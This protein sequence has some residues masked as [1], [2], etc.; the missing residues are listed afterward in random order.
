MSRRGFRRLLLLVAGFAVFA[1]VVGSAWMIRSGVREARLAESRE[2]GMRLYERGEHAMALPL[3]GEYVARVKDDAAALLA[4][5]ECQEQ[6]PQPN[7][8]HIRHAINAARLAVEVEPG[9]VDGHEVLL[10]LYAGAGYTTE[11]AE[12]ASGLLAIDPFHRDAHALL[13]VAHLGLGNPD[14][15]ADAAVAF[16][17]RYPGDLG[18]H[19]AMMEVRRARGDGPM[20]ILEAWLDEPVARSLDDRAAYHILVS[21]A[22]AR[23]VEIA[24]RGGEG[25]GAKMVALAIDSARQAASITPRDA[26]EAFSITM[27]L[28]ELAAL[29]RDRSLGDLA[30][31]LTDRYL[32]DELFG[33]SHAAGES[34]AAWWRLDDARALELARR[35]D[36]ETDEPAALGWRLFLADA[37]P[38]S[39]LGCPGCEARLEGGGSAESRGWLAVVRT[40]RDLRGGAS[41][42]SIRERVSAIGSPEPAAVARFIEGESL[43]RQGQTGSAVRALREVVD[44][45]GTVLT[46]ARAHLTLADVLARRGDEDEA[47][48]VLD[49]LHDVGVGGA[50]ADAIA[51]RFMERRLADP[52]SASARETARRV[53]D[54]I[55]SAGTG[56]RDDPDLAFVRA[57]LLLIV[58]RLEE[59]LA[60]ARRAA[61]M[62][63]PS[64]PLALTALVDVVQPLDGALAEEL[65]GL[66][67]H[68]PS[69]AIDVAAARAVL[70]AREGDTEGGL[71]A[72][73]DVRVTD[74]GDVERLARARAG[75][76]DRAGLPGA[77]R[78]MGEL[79]D[80]FPSSPEVQ[81]EVLRSRSAWT[82]RA[83]VGRAIARLREATGDEGLEWRV[84]RARLD[85]IE[86]EGLPGSDRQAALAKT[87]QSLLDIKRQDAQNPEIL[88]L[89]AETYDR[90]GDTDR[91]LRHLDEA[92][93]PGRRA[94]V[95]PTLIGLL[96][97]EGRRREAA[98]QLD[99]FAMVADA[100]VGVVRER[101]ALL[102]LFGRPGEALADRRA[103]AGLG[104]LGDIVAYGRLLAGLGEV[105]GVRT[106]VED[107]LGGER[108]PERVRAAAGLL[109]S[110][111]LVGEAV[112]VLDRALGEA[113]GR[114]A[115]IGRLLLGFS[116]WDAAIERLERAHESGDARAAMMLAYAWMESGRMDRA[117]AFVAG[118]TGG[119]LALIASALGGGSGEVG[120]VMARV[121]AA[122][123]VS[124]EADG[125]RLAETASA[126][127]SGEIDGEGLRAA[128]A[129]LSEEM[130][131]SENVWRARLSVLRLEQPEG[132][133]GA[134]E[135]CAGA[136]WDRSWPLQELAVAHLGAGRLDEAEG[137]A[138]RMGDRLGGET[139]EADV[140]RARIASRRGDPA[141]VVNWLLR[142]R[143]R[144]LS[145]DRRTV[146]AGMLLA[147][148]AATGRGAEAE[149]AI[150][151]QIAGGGD[152]AW[153]YLDA[154]GAL[155]AVESETARRWLTRVD[156]LV[157][158]REG[159][160][161][162][163]WA[164][165]AH[166]SG[167]AGD[168]ERALGLL[169]E[170]AH[171]FV[172][173][174]LEALAG[175][176]ESAAAWYERALAMDGTNAV[177]RNNYAYF[178]ANLGRG[179]EARGHA[180]EAIRLAEAGGA[181]G[182][183][184]GAFWHTLG[185]AHR[186]RSSLGE[187]EAALRR[188]IERAGATGELVI[189]LAEVLEEM[190]RL[191]EAAGVLEGL[192]DGAELTGELGDRLEALRAG[193]A[194]GG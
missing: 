115:E 113:P 42:A 77:A 116:A 155:P 6:V 192:P 162:M 20:Q 7:A 138:R 101:A 178:L 43:R 185:V 122:G 13:I 153:A 15:A 107:L 134:L 191:E 11:L 29:T 17:E 55:E 84:A 38:E 74:P 112:G 97:R 140:L 35:I 44:G 39:G 169:G 60:E 99:A 68:D 52:M 144:L 187:A 150:E 151:N 22:A 3:L 23:A 90:L 126:F 105:E 33:P 190:G 181:P 146:E 117:S 5:A 120:V 108:S 104:E 51:I 124:G 81:A 18:A 123:R 168:A 65:L 41:P 176:P 127:L 78:A 70:S 72:F 69:S 9:L 131:R 2:E 132:L 32:D 95:Y 37:A 30:D 147:G 31:G 54:R 80:T 184:V 148:M 82:D 24:S 164:G 27:W 48:R 10:R 163:A 66:I 154:S 87:A 47:Q 102:E 26:D 189:E 157:E 85:L 46:R 139:F 143:D 129:G 67:E 166:K 61:G 180:E 135:A 159:E 96:M 98:L 106:V 110:V 136:L 142:H 45:G 34:R 103:L 174:T 170:G 21:G 111:G 59:G 167:D 133:V 121:L 64:R 1:A 79:S 158:G 100:P 119:E 76:M 114:D 8:R 89:I 88:I 75:F 12:T 91:A 83:V 92:V 149:A 179:E 173:A 19:A 175:R 188:G 165:L 161:G 25:G 16:L 49:R 152:W 40:A 71:A 156:G 73:D 186:A 94:G 193:V 160:R 125:V 53:L 56:S 86:S 145:S 4:Y 137:A 58:G 183:V 36:T 93:G 141:G 63:P 194:E 118:E 28:R 109:I 171:P 50:L 182:G 172:L 128:L 14:R 177:V 62:G 130:P 57:R